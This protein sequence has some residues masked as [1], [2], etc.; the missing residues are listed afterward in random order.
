MLGSKLLKNGVLSLMLVLPA[1]VFADDAPPIYG[2]QL[3]TQE[4]IQ[5]HRNK[6][7]SAK[8]LEE[9]ERIRY[10]HHEQMKIRAKEKGVVL[11]D[12]PPAERGR[13]NQEYNQQNQPGLGNGMGGSQGGGRP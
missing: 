2:Q 12:E 5:A 11:P 3:M 7:R 8:T 6:M 1:A 10:E 13:L 4:E 9:R